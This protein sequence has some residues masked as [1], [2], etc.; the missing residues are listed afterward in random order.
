MCIRDRYGA[1]NK[2]TIASQSGTVN[3]I[4]AAQMN[5]THDVISASIET[6]SYAIQINGV[7]ATAIGIDGGGSGIT[8]TENRQYNILVP[9]IQ[10]LEVPG[11]SVGFSLEAQ[12]GKSVDGGESAYVKTPIGGILAN[13]NNEFTAPLTI[14]STI[15]ETN[16]TTDSSAGNKSAVVTATLSGSSTLS[17]VIDMNRCSL[18]VVGNRLNDATTNSSAYNDAA[19]GQTY[20]AD[21]AAQGIS[22]LNRYITKRVDLNNEADVL[23]VFLNA[24]KPSGANIDL[25]FKVLAAGDDSDFDSLTWTAAPPDTAIVTNDSGAYNEVHYTIDP[26]IGK[27]GS[28]A[29]KIVL[30]STN[31][32]NVP[33][34]KD[35]RAVAAT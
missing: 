30:R 21:T 18:T 4:T 27:F 19:N 12:S 11:T 23:D 22:N 5:T 31:T 10:T 7:A 16:Y 29:F 24:N 3:G 14:A 1:N 32:S 20:V 35:F 9:Q 6:D 26:A 15:N 13:S 2:V 25:Y 17:P 34:I 28:F 8:A 33:T